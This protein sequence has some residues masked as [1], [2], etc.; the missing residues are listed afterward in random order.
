MTNHRHPMSKSITH[1]SHVHHHLES[2]EKNYIILMKKYHSSLQHALNANKNFLLA[3]GSEFRKIP[4]LK[5]LFW[6]HPIWPQMRETLTIGSHWPIQSL[7]DMASRHCQGNQFWQPQR[8]KQK[9][10]F[11]TTQT[12]WKGCEIWILPPLL[13]L[14]EAKLIPNLLFAPMNIQHQNTK[15]HCRDRKNCR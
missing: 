10:N 13:P 5:K 3:M 14:K 2:M 8:C 1:R 15:Y 12:H 11:T 6:H 7:D 4:I 9:L